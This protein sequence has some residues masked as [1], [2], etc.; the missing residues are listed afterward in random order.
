MKMDR[1]AVR[2]NPVSEGRA[3]S[4]TSSVCF[5]VMPW[6]GKSSGRL[7]GFVAERPVR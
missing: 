7:R 6:P 5:P 4:L 2:R 1:Y 3:R